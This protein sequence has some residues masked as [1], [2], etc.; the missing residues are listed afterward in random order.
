MRFNRFPGRASIRIL[1]KGGHSFIQQGPLFIRQFDSFWNCSDTVPDLANE[2]DSLVHW[3][4]EG[5]FGRNL[6]QGSYCAI[7]LQQA[8]NNDYVR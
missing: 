7:A 2:F 1:L 4:M 8:D 3:E 5:I 6:F